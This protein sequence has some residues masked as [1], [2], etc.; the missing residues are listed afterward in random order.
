MLSKSLE[1]SKILKTI[2]Q[3]QRVK[4][5]LETPSENCDILPAEEQTMEDV[6]KCGNQSVFCC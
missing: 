6:E 2:F 3:I 1:I 5:S 4:D